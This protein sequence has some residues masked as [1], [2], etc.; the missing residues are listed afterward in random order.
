MIYKTNKKIHF[1]EIYYSRATNFV[2]RCTYVCRYLTFWM[3]GAICKDDLGLEV[4]MPDK[5]KICLR[6]GK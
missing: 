5:V 3:N 4:N 6:S 2:Y 1:N